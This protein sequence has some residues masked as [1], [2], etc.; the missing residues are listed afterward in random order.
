MPD[1]T[2][3]ELIV[4]FKRGDKAAF[5]TLY[6][7]YQRRIGGYCIRLLDNRDSVPD[8]V[9]T[10]FEKAY[11]AAATLEKSEMFR[12]WLFAIARNE[13]YGSLRSARGSLTIPLTDDVWDTHTPHEE[14]VRNECHASL[15]QA[16][17]R[18]KPEYREV[19]VLRHIEGFH[20]AEIAVITGDSMS[21]VESRLFKARKALL[22][23]FDTI[24]MERDVS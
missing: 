15:E 6:Q 8:I 18:L 19:L 13:C 24:A 4:R 2:D 14:Y 10:V 16:L 11:S 21:S 23:I 12:S 1:I 20:Y 3:S 17:D 9:Q 5:G 7:R 22:K